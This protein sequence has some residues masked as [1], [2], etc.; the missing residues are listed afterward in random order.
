VVSLWHDRGK[1][2]TVNLTVQ[3]LQT[4]LQSSKYTDILLCTIKH[5]E[6]QTRGDRSA[7]GE[8]EISLAEEFIE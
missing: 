5:A 7:P 4:D 6:M 2:H 3:G 1:W 8:E